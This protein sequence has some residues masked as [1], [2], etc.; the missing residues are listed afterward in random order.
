M[1]DWFAPAGLDRETPHLRALV[2]PGFSMKDLVPG[3]LFRL[4]EP[5][6]TLV[7]GGEIFRAVG[8][9]FC[10]EGVWGI[11]AESCE[12]Y[13]SHFVAENGQPMSEGQY[14]LMKSPMLVLTKNEASN[15]EKEKAVR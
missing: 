9:P 12:E 11:G 10:I 6:G 2:I 3:D 13:T 15:G 14:R 8:K 5:D 1:T 7:A 4:R